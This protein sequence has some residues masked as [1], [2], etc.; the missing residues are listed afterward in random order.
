MQRRTL[1]ENA[2]NPS[3]WNAPY[4]NGTERTPKSDSNNGQMVMSGWYIIVVSGMQLGW[5][6]RPRMPG[7][8]ARS[9][10]CLAHPQM[11][12]ML[13]QDREVAP[14]SCGS[15]YWDPLIAATPGDGRGAS[16][17]SSTTSARTSAGHVLQPNVHTAAASL[18]MAALVF[19]WQCV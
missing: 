17:T 12:C 18:M 19:A 6:R 4:P 2:S 14:A 3:V 15:F 1:S 11:Q 8:L 10:N 7:L 13:T 9:T 5:T 16:L